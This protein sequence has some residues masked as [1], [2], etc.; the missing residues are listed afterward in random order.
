MPLLPSDNPLTTMTTSSNHSP[1]SLPTQ[2][3]GL[4]PGY[5]HVEQFGPDEDYDDDEVEDNADR[6][7]RET[8]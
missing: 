7:W 3:Q 5:K 1:S 4:F 6:P 2:T 8:E